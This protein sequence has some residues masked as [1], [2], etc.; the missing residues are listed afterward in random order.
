M[1]KVRI[2]EHISIDGV[3]QAPGGPNEDAIG[4]A[5]LFAPAPSMTRQREPAW[6]EWRLAEP[7]GRT[8]PETP[9]TQGDWIWPTW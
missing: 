9:N 4:R 7:H 6:F 5:G 2:I 8:S 3:I 1:R